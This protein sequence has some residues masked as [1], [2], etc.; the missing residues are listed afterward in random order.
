MSKP[1]AILIAGPTASGK[2]QLAVDIADR[3]G[4]EIINTDSMQIYAVLRVLT[5]RPSKA[6]ELAI[7]HHL[8]GHVAPTENFS[9]AKWLEQA[10]RAME[11]VRARHR[12]PIFVGGTGLYFKALE[13]GLAEVPEIPAE[14]RQNIRT[15][16]ES[17]G[18]WLLHQR[19]ASVDPES[20]A[21]LRPGD[22]QRIARALEVI[23]TTGKPLR[24][25]QKEAHSIS[26]L[27][28]LNATKILLMPERPILHER[29][30]QRTK[31]MLEQ[32]ALEEIGALLRLKL[33]GS[34]TAMQAIGVKPLEAHLNNELTR[35]EAVEKMQ[36][37][38]RQYAK[39]QST[40][41]RGQH[42][43]DWRHV[44]S[45]DEGLEKISG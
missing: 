38:T 14:I 12:I 25:F 5:A 21:A 8:Y 41:F 45:A 13:S 43:E 23:E 44:T 32:G 39:R 4:G 29:I 28:K 18:S 16:L 40:W 7:P 9:V 20:A 30:N 35:A 19:L 31:M 17:R 42:G 33:P 2:S 36:A 6:H 24:V 15:T 1:D 26:L 22:G 10:K 34:A 37:A 11:D 27:N 3:I